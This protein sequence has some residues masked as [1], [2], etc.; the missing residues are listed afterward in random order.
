M[1]QRTV[2]RPRGW[3]LVLS[4][5]AVFLLPLLAAVGMGLFFRD[6]RAYQAATIFAALALVLVALPVAYRMIRK[7][8]G[9][10]D[11]QQ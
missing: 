3:T 5:A 11:E 7:R 1:G 4:A 2:G 9:E 8:R 10:S 6:N